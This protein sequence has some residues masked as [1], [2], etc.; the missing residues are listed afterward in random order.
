MNSLLY[1][2]YILT[3]SAI[4]VSP[5]P[6]AAL[7]VSHAIKY[8]KKAVITNALGSVAAATILIIIAL[9]LIEKT[10]PENFIPFLSVIGSLYLIYTGYSNIQST[11]NDINSKENEKKYSVFIQSFLTGLSNPKDI[12]FFIVFLPQFLDSSISFIYSSFF[13]VVGWVICD[14]TIMIGYGFFSMRLKRSLSI[15]F[16]RKINKFMGI[17]IITIGLILLLSSIKK[18]VII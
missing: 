9:V 17:F 1:I 14:S 6:N 3:V 13:L 4:I 18:A 16:S 15:N 8:G 7:M 2:S 12:I 11:N 10:I 5:G